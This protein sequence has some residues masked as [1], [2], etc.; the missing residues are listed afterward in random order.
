MAALE[1]LDQADIPVPWPDLGNT[2]ETGSWTE[3]KEDNLLP[4]I[5]VALMGS[6]LANKFV[7][8]KAA[9]TADVVG[10]DVARADKNLSDRFVVGDD[11]TP[12]EFS[13]LSA[14]TSKEFDA[15]RS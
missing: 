13:Q 5:G 7:H 8:P 9:Q 4:A 1:K 15:P 6:R 14:L 2:R 10:R 12:V 11:V 3:G